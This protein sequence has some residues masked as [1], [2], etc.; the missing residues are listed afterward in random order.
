MYSSFYRRSFVI[1]TA[2]LMAYLLMRVLEH[3]GGA[4]GWA[5]VLAFMLLPLQE[6]LTRSL[7]GRGALSAGILT[8]LTP[9][10]VMA[11]IAMLAVAFAGQVAVL[12]TYL[13]GH[14]AL[15]SYS[16]LLQRLEGYSIVGSAVH[17]A[18]ENAPISAEQVQGWLTEGAQSVL[19]TAAAMG[20]TVALNVFGTLFSFVMMLFLLFFFLQDGRAMLASLTRLIPMETERRA[21]LLKYLADVTRA[22]VFGST[23]TAL[24]QG[25]FVGVG[26]AIVGL[27]SPVVFGVLATI[28]AFLPAGAAAVLVPALL[29]LLAVGR[30]GAAIFMAVWLAA[31]WVVENVLRPLL[32]AQRAEVSTLAIFV[33]AIGGAAAFGI[34]GL[35]IGPVLISFAVALLKFAGENL[36]KTES[37]G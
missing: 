23:V 29:Y 9:F 19:K 17:W 32:T 7:K 30:W 35:V 8:G 13:R 31:M 20:G 1:A 24:V 37:G 15:L 6:G 18:R 16:E 4:L 10:F 28:V 26:F 25:I 3:L 14:T 27:P 11:P 5:A 22:V 12:L 21:Q 33:G 2:V 34:L 36:P